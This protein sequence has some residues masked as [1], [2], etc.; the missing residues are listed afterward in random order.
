MTTE[1]GHE[2]D[3]YDIRDVDVATL[4]VGRPIKEDGC[5]FAK[6]RCGHE[7]S[8]LCVTV[9]GVRVLKRAMID[10]AA[11]PRFTTLLDLRAP[12]AIRD[13]MTRVDDYLVQEV[14]ANRTKWFSKGLDSNVIDEFYKRSVVPSSV[15]GGNIL[16]IR[17]VQPPDDLDRLLLQHGDAAL[18]ATL[19]CRGLRFFKHCFSMEWELR[20][21]K[22]AER[23]TFGFE[24]TGA[25]AAPMFEEGS[26]EEEDAGVAG[27][28]A[29]DRVVGCAI[30]PSPEELR[31]I[32]ADMQQK[33]DHLREAFERMRERASSHVTR[34]AEL[35]SRV[36]ACSQ[37]S[38]TSGVELDAV[39][40][41]LDHI[42][43]EM[44]ASFQ[45]DHERHHD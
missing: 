34:L 25:A 6:V 30:G 23:E 19:L 8:R 29:S 43:S 16:R 35:E 11:F 20:W 5:L 27:D 18:D 3:D 24:P 17:V 22:S 4:R 33:I 10:D 28:D 31:S 21:A 40:D 12:R 38:Q 32:V 36:S 9:P 41:E 7:K 1:S 39:A 26:D 44:D 42:C 14:Q 45:H 15:A 2:C 13:Q 37:T